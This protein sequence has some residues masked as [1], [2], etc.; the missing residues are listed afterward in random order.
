MIDNV[1]AYDN[2]TLA[3]CLT[4]LIGSLGGLLYHGQNS[5]FERVVG[6]SIRRNTSGLGI[7]M[8][9]QE[10]KGNHKRNQIRSLS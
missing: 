8:L 4:Q 1:R 2:S 5:H 9:S 3:L 10:Y 6:T 7:L